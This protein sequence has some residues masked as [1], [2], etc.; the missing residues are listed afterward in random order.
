MGGVTTISVCS[1]SDP[2]LNGRK[3]LGVTAAC[4]L[5]RHGDVPEVSRRQCSE[6]LLPD[7]ELSA[8]RVYLLHHY[9][10]AAALTNGLRLHNAE[11]M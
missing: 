5:N 6:L 11:N 2:V 7:A 9:R 3:I 8:A 1:T 4:L 10:L